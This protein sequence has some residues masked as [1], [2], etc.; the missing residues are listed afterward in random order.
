MAI[1]TSRTETE[2]D[3]ITLKRNAKGS[4]AWEI[5]IYGDD[6]DAMIDMTETANNRLRALYA[7]EKQ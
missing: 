4:Y 2:A 5:K 7:K 3:S 6:L 1:T